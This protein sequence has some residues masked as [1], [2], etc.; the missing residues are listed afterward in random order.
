MDVWTL[1]E[2]Q[3]KIDKEYEL[4]VK[5]ITHIESF[6]SN[7][8]TKLDSINKVSNEA[9]QNKKAKPSSVRTKRS[10]AKKS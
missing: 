9:V 1:N 4:L 7:L 8:N 5:R 3:K 10:T 6:L 2:K